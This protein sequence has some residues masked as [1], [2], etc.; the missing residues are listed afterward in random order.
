[1]N[2]YIRSIGAIS[3]H[4]HPAAIQHTDHSIRCA[5]PDLSGYVDPKLTRRMSHVIKMGIA[6]AMEALKEANI[7]QPDAIITG[8]AYGCLDE[9]G[10]FLKKQ[11]QQ[12][13]TM[14]TPTA[15]IQSTHNT[16]GG[17][18]GLLLHCNGYNNT[19]VHRGFSFEHALHDAMMMLLDN[20]A[21][22]VLVGAV[23]EITD[24]S[25]ALLSRFALYKN[26]AVDGEGAA[27]LVLS[28]Q[29][30]E[31]DHAI[32]KD[33]STL[34]KPSG[35]K[36]ISDHIISFLA[37]HSLSPADIDLVISGKNGD[38]KSD[39]IY[40]NVTTAIFND[41]PAIGFK[42]LSGEHPTASSYAL[43]LAARILKQDEIPANISLTNPVQKI[44][45]YNHSQNIHHAFHLITAC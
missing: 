34:Y 36:E 30:S 8:T 31:N 19:F 43:A 25:H 11:I 32:L 7:Q 18:I 37:M 38:D 10:V 24:T 21:V 27:F 3:P 16:V 42:H 17:Q 40:R 29:P 22:N 26:G 20:Q 9:T 4:S 5:D 12:N 45:I 35:I 13:E 6:A 23:D 39:E 33:V 2:I 28:N 44:L 15:F 14:L 1:M 41:T